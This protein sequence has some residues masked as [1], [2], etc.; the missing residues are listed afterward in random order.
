MDSLASTNWMAVTNAPVLV[1]GLNA[2]ILEPAAPQAYYR[3][4]RMK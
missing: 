3:L 4:R 2:V 1:N